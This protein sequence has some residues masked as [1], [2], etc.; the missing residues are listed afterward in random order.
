MSETRGSFEMVANINALKVLVEFFE[1]DAAEILQDEGLCVFQK[2]S[3]LVALSLSV[4][5]VVGSFQT[6]LSV[7]DELVSTISFEG[8][9]ELCIRGDSLGK[10]LHAGFFAGEAEVKCVVRT[11]PAVSVKWSGINS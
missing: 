8:L 5:E 3:G 10:F 1:S 7:Q 2:L 6:T 11:S 9:N 4:N